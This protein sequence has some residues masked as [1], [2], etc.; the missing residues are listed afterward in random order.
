MTILLL[1]DMAP[2]LNHTSGIVTNNW[3]EFLLEDS[4]EIVCALIKNPELEMSIPQDKKRKIKFL[5]IDKPNE[6]F[7]CSENE[8]FSKLKIFWKS[9]IWNSYNRF[10]V[11]PRISEQVSNF[12]KTNK[13]DLLFVSI[14]GQTMTYLTRSVAKSLKL[15]YVAQTWDPLEWWLGAHNFDFISKWLSLREFAM[16]CRHAKKFMA[17]SWAM[18]VEYERKYKVHCVTNLPSLG[19]EKDIQPTKKS[20]RIN[21]AL[22]GQIYARAELDILVEA[23]NQMDWRFKKKKICLHLYGNSSL[24]AYSQKDKIIVHGHIK[25]QRLINELKKYDLLYCPYWFSKR[26]EKPCK[27]SFPG[28]L[29]TYLKSGVP[30]LMHAPDYA[31]PAKFLRHH[32]AAF[33]CNSLSKYDMILTL[34]DV[35][36]S[37]RTKINKVILNG[38]KAFNDYLT[39]E[40]MK[41]SLLVSLG[42]LAPNAVKDFEKLRNIYK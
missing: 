23:L 38:V 3:C 1:T 17:M 21:I 40:Q 14:Q 27:L 31:S 32:D 41:K 36:N 25:Q 39:Y 30:I 26:Y 42:L 6:F 4:H 15:E 19:R 22:A 34:N 24:D 7:G 5:V 2:C 33:F 12:A 35:F 29:T 16:V 8:N 18:S 37:D 11:L 9:F 28:K 20:S 13:V 10:V